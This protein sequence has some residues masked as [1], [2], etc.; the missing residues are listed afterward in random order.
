MGVDF[1][2]LARWG[3]LKDAMGC[4]LYLCEYCILGKKTR[5]QFGTAIHCM[6]GI[7]DYVHTYVWE[8]PYIIIE[9]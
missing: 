6:K 8:L 3:L 7:L 5:D 2:S 1:Y 4:K 9:R